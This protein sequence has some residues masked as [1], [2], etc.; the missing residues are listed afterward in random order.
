[1]IAALAATD[2]GAT[3]TVLERDSEPYGATG[4]SQGGTSARPDLG[5]SEKDAGVADSAELF[6]ADILKKTVVG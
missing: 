3:V 2:A 6:V 1:M 4:M 5:T